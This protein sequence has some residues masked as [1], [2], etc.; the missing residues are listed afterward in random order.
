MAAVGEEA[1][2]PPPTRPAHACGGGGDAGFFAFLKHGV[3]VPARNC[4][5][6]V[7]LVALHAA[8]SVSWLLVDKLALTV[9]LVPAI[10][11]VYDVDDGKLFFSQLGELLAGRPCVLP[12]GAAYLAMHRHTPRSLLRKVRGNLRGPAVT[13]VAGWAAAYAYVAAVAGAFVSSVLAGVFLDAL[14]PYT[15]NGVAVLAVPLAVLV[16]LL[17]A[18]VYTFYLPVLLDVAVVASVAEPGRRG[19]AALRR[20][21]RLM[22]GTKRVAQAVVYTVVTG[23]MD[24]KIGKMARVT[25]AWLLKTGAPKAVMW[26]A[27]VLFYLAFAALNACCMV[28]VSAYYLEC[29]RVEEDKEDTRD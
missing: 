5:L 25:M 2:L 11:D 7:P 15:M 21:W 9:G 23:A 24:K 6:F 13:V 19:A 27:P 17:G 26:S 8:R 1:P 16:V 12:A 4:R 20:A 18:L 3:L 28:A 14:L 29:R 22:R 10:G